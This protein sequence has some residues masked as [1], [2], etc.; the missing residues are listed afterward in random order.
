M[1]SP[2]FVEIGE[3]V[4]IGKR[5]EKKVYR[6]AEKRLDR[7]SLSFFGRGVRNLKVSVFF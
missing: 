1:R 5:D 4:V 2:D 7:C 3:I 6:E